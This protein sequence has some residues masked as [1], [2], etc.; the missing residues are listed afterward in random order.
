MKFIGFATALVATVCASGSQD[1]EG[2]DKKVSVQLYF[3]SECPGCRQMITGS[4]KEA[5]A[6]DGFLHM[7]EVNLF[8][9][10]NASEKKNADGTW[11]FTCQHGASECVWNQIET[12]GLAWVDD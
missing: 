10:G 5:F 9:Y 1:V 4:F 8:P 11:D 7:A 3:E 2:L 6:A 12:C